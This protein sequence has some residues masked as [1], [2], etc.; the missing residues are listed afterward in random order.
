M[1]ETLPLSKPLVAAAAGVS[2]RATVDTIAGRAGVWG[3][4]LVF[5]SNSSS[6][7]KPQQPAAYN[8]AALNAVQFKSRSDV[9]CVRCYAILW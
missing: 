1:F 3:L 6:F 7:L 9:K 4:V 5:Y 8:T 2:Q